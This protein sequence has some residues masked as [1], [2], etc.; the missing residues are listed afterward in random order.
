MNR[1]PNATPASAATAPAASSKT[2]FALP[3]DL[4]AQ[5]HEAQRLVVSEL[6][7]AEARD[8][9]ALLQH[10]QAEY[11]ERVRGD[12]PVAA[13]AYLAAFNAR[14][15]FRPPLDALIR[16]YAR[17]RSAA[18]LS[19][20]YDALFKAAHSPGERAE[21]LTLRAEL[22]EDRLDDAKGAAE[23]YEQAV[24]ADPEYRV[25][26]LDL[27][28]TALRNGDRAQRVRAL[29]RLADLTR[30]DEWRSLLLLELAA[31]HAAAGSE[32][33]DEAARCIREAAATGAGRWR[34]YAELERFG[35]VHDRPADVVDA[36]EGRAE[37]A[38]RYGRGEREA[39]TSGAFSIQR[40]RSLEEAR[41]SAAE[42]RARAAWM[43]LTALRDPDGARATMQR[44]LDAEPDDARYRFLAMM[45]AD[46]AGDVAAASAHA[47]WLL[48]REYGDASVRASLQ[49]RVAESAADRGDL[50]GAT[51]ALQAA[52]ALAPQSA[53]VR[54]ALV[55]QLI[56]SN[57]G[58]LVVQEFDRL[59]EGAEPGAAR[60]SLR[61][62]GAAL[63]LALRHD[64]EGAEQRFRMAC[65]DDAADIVSRRAL[66]ALQGRLRA[67][68]AAGD[69]HAQVEAARARVAA[70]HALLPH[71]ADD[72]E[73]T[74]L[75]LERFFAERYELRDARAAAVTAEQLVEATR[76]SQWAMESAA[77]LWAAAGAMSVA[78]RWALAVADHLTD[79]AHAADARA[80]R[81]AAARW[82]WAANEEPRAREIAVAA[83]REH[84]GDDYLAALALR[85]ALTSRDETLTLDI[86]TRRAD[87][88]DDPE[89]AARWMLVA[90]ATLH[91]AGADAVSRTALESALGR[92]P[93]SPAVRAAV[94]A[95]TRWRGDPSLRAR[96]VDA[97]LDAGDAGDEELALGLELALVRAFVDH[98][99]AAAAELMDRLANVDATVPVVALLR[100]LVTG[101]RQGANSEAALS[102]WQAVL[103]SLPAGDRLGVAVELEVAG[104]LGASA[105][106]RDQAVAARELAQEDHP[107]HAAPR[108]LALLDAVQR[109]G[110]EDVPQAL[111]RVADHGGDAADALRAVALTTLRAQARAAEFRALAQQHPDLAASAIGGSEAQAS[112]D[113]VATHV[114]ALRRRA[115]LAH[116]DTR[117]AHDRAIA[118]WSSLAR[119]DEEALTRAASVI[120]NHPDD[121]ASLD[122]VRC[123]ARRLKRWP[124]VASTCAALA[125]RVRDPERAA[126]YWEEAGVVALDA[127]QDWVK[128]ENWLRAALDASPTRTLAYQKLRALL[129]AQNNPAALEALVTRRLAWVK[130]DAE[131]A[132]VLW[133]QA[134]LRRALG[135]R[136][137]ALESA[138]QVVKLDPNHV[139]ALAL[140][141]EIHAA[142]GRFAETAEAL[143]ALAACREAPRAQR[144]AA[145]QG[146]VA[147]FDQRLGLPERALEQL[148]ALV[149]EGEADDAAIERAV[150]I[151]TSAELWPAALRFALLAVDR[152]EKGVPHAAAMMRVVEIHR[153]RLLD[154][155][156][157]AVQAR[158]AHNAYPADLGILKALQELSEDN[159]RQRN[160]K[161]TLDAVRELLRAEG[162]TVERVSGLIEAARSGGETALESLAQ[163]LASALGR[164]SPAPPTTVPARGSL[165]DPALVLRYRHPDDSGRAVTLLETLLPDLAELSGA[166][167]DS[168]RVGWSDRIRGAHATRAALLPLLRAVGVEEFEL[169]VGGNDPTRVTAI[170]GD[171]VAVVLGAGASPALDGAARQ[172]FVRRLLLALRGAA[173]LAHARGETVVPRTRAALAYAE[174]PVAAPAKMYEAH[175][176]AVGKAVSRRVRKAIAE[177]GRALA[178][179]PHAPDEIA[180]AARAMLST[181]RRGALAVGGDVAAAA[182]DLQRAEG[183]RERPVHELLAKEPA[184]V[185]LAL[186][187]V[188]DALA[189]VMRELGTDRR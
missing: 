45:L 6:Q 74:A 48:G 78:A 28:R 44:A 110:R 117:V 16:L 57:E 32:H 158:K 134:R 88:C 169:Y 7:A 38:E 23:L 146:A 179:D 162:P 182:R 137:G 124:M 53:A 80:W 152:V 135:L 107:Q 131:R 167:T 99:V 115:A 166:T 142:S 175:A 163:R 1:T 123:A 105:A 47:Q 41:S 76:E 15:A 26:W 120:V 51:A 81:A 133:E 176:K 91:A 42:L 184:G 172:E 177:S 55:E 98:D 62:A 9:R 90:S 94:V 136:E 101:A 75:L 25:A 73:R 160:A 36:L 37:L 174:L 77:S 108:V 141:T 10:E 4:A 87:A 126:A 147:L 125:A 31:E 89:T 150:Q 24:G 102:A 3:D 183:L 111:L 93:L 33:L 185:E 186:Y 118:N 157:A 130:G 2:A 128:A 161:E 116:G 103:S 82:A 109:E 189:Q 12:E 106:T 72:D 181:A 144:L 139:A 49:F 168:F 29:T 46:H 63:S 18:N 14:P 129:Q 151:A 165:R 85:L 132:E 50:A 138:A 127:M 21:S 79:P 13:R 114:D 35:E 100:A 156:A 145:R 43:R 40:L 83:H 59:A 149:T 187:S 56:A 92:A 148:D 121:L 64:V 113:R 104:A 84:P 61:R 96:L 22:F 54:G 170:G 71:A 52:L 180:K 173:A 67:R 30:D 68:I 17:R 112:L 11:E 27:Y 69:T 5:I 86:A 143:A 188:S 19:K 159:E 95:S 140:V 58:L 153:D 60:A 155:R 65:E 97:S 119:H 66:V 34:A 8:M 20:L 164:E 39:G 70:V 122:V 154:R 178:A 171:P